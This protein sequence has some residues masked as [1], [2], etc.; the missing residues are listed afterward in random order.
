MK[1]EFVRNPYNYDSDDLST[2]TGLECKDESRTEQEHLAESDIN[3][4]AHTFMKTGHAPQVLRLPTAGDFSGIFDFQTAMNT[5][6]QAKDEFM[7]LPAKIRTRF[8]NDPAQL[9]EFVQDDNNRDEAIKLG[10]IPKPDLTSTEKRA[11]MPTALSP[12][13]KE[14]NE[15]GP[16]ADTTKPTENTP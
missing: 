6:K 8:G 11:T 12:T 14:S 15:S 1:K 5:I 16:R 7:S 13:T 2:E 3:Y 4:I 9:L 10:F